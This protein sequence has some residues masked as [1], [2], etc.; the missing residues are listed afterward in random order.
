[1]FHWRNG[2]RC[3]TP[4]RAGVNPFVWSIQ[5]RCIQKTMMKI[6]LLSLLVAAVSASTKVAVI[7]LG[8]S[9]TVH[10]TTSKSSFTSVSGVSSF[11]NA[12]HTGSKIQ[13]AGMTVVP[14]LFNKPDAGVVISFSG[15]DIDNMPE[16]TS[17]FESEGVKG[18]IGHME[19][20]G[21]NIDTLTSKIEHTKTVENLEASQV[22]SCCDKAKLSAVKVNAA[23]SNAADLDRQ[24]ADVLKEI[25]LEAKN[26]GKTVIIH[27]VVEDDNEVS[28]R[29][30]LQEENGEGQG[31][32]EN[33]NGN[34]G[35]QSSS[36]YYS[37]GYW[38]NG[39]FVSTYKT[40]FQIQHFNIVLWTSLGLVAV[41][42]FTV[43][44]MIYMPLE[45]DTL[46]FG[47]SA[48]MMGT[49]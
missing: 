3:V 39:E 37:S 21:R 16:L 27:I 18:V 2:D 24:L 45:P 11:W 13:E 23:N 48:K 43:Y 46:L 28:T 5:H 26:A 9:G 14:D 25:D 6:V 38:K 7:E 42:F 32:G 36:G 4:G 20:A 12:L 30:H 49:D 31:E 22:K 44:L 10:R 15:A 40:I 47:E 19:V 41:L 34:N 17:L 33:V 35:Q 29:R 1:M 8:A